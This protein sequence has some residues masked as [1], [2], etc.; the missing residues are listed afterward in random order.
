[1]SGNKADDI[2]GVGD[3]F[4]AMS[5]GSGK[6]RNEQQD[7]VSKGGCNTDGNVQ[8]Y[9][10]IPDPD[11]S[12]DEHFD[13][14]KWKF[15]FKN[16]DDGWVSSKAPSSGQAEPSSKPQAEISAEGIH[17]V[18]RREDRSGLDGESNSE[19]SSEQVIDLGGI[20]MQMLPGNYED[21][22]ESSSE[23]VVDLGD[24]ALQMLPADHE[25][26]ESNDAG[27]IDDSEDVGLDDAGGLGDNG[28][29]DD[30][31]DG[32]LDDDF[33]D[34]GLDDDFDDDYGVDYD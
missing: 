18:D 34:G 24:I 6:L 5:I 17:H 19:G 12:D 8:R 22:S 9:F 33:S 20:G 29:D 31:D 27:A 26:A 28:F 13:P 30:F 32:G 2:D 11:D 4:Q 21:D 25:D 10:T 16:D 14:N 3:R 7:G 15:L 1:M 23:E